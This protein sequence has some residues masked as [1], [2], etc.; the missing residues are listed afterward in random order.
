MEK[1]DYKHIVVTPTTELRFDKAKFQEKL[2]QG[3]YV[4]DNDLVSMLL[5]L[6][7]QVEAESLQR[8]LNK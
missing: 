2:K 8:R 7:E 6:W 1:N 5:D 4:T 3:K